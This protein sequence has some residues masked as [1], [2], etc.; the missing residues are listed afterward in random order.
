MSEDQRH[1]G[2][3]STIIAKIMGDF[4]ITQ[5]MVDKIKTMID[6][7]DIQQDEKTTTIRVKTKEMTIIIN[8]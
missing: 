4:G 8:K 1:G 5:E 7:V 3:A 2:L 6:N